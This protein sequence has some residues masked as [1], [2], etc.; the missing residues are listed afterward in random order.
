MK[1]EQFKFYD[2]D[3]FELETMVVS[4]NSTN[5]NAHSDKDK[6]ILVVLEK[7][8]F[9][10]SSGGQPSDNGFL[11]NENFKGFV[12]E[13]L[14]KTNHIIHKVRVEHG[15]LKQ[16]DKVI[17][18]INKE[19]RLRLK[20]MHSVEHLFANTLIKL[21]LENNFEI[22]LEKIKLDEGE[23]S[24]FINTNNNELLNWDFLFKAEERVNNL[25]KEGINVFIH[26]IDEGDED[27]IDQFIKKGLR[28]KKDRI[29][30]GFIRIIEFN[31][32][33]TTIDLSACTG[34]HV[35]NTKELIAFLILDYKNL[36]S[37]KWQIKFTVGDFVFKKLNAYSKEFR[38]IKTKLGK[39]TTEVFNTVVKQI[40]DKN[41]Y[42]EKYYDY[43]LN[44]ILGLKPKVI[45]G[46][47]LYN[48]SFNNEEQRVL[49][50]AASKLCEEENRVVCLLNKKDNEVNNT[51]KD[52][53]DNKN[54]SD[55]KRMFRL[56]S[57][58]LLMASKNLNIDLKTIYS[59]LSDRI[60]EILK[61]E[62][63]WKV[64]FKGGGNSYLINSQMIITSEVLDGSDKTR[65]D[66][67]KNK[68]LG[69]IKE[70]LEREIS[71]VNKRNK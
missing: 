41:Y 64:E 1:R 32:N 50:R 37:G 61:K 49:V 22:S 55:N 63:N 46:I 62:E 52:K 21:S 12:E 38:R 10:P 45:G 40:N 51:D 71:G 16:G 68:I 26:Y 9:R 31:K 3:I 42:K 2:N 36:G 25:I 43:L 59:K 70:E 28:I 69:V 15:T 33:N 44:F 47:N 65:I 19:R 48:Y 66:N 35:K 29:K 23:S 24:I 20:R 53:L 54:E 39:E 8:P 14:D 7:T 27:K 58:L 60:T 11:E 57:G 30:G 4:V 17:A 67:I 5:N 6:V 13:V 56:T 18:K 34:T